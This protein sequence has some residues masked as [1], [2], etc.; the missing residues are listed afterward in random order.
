M[1]KWGLLAA[2]LA[3]AIGVP[4]LYRQMDNR[5][6]CRVEE[7]FAA[8]F[9]DLVVGVHSAAVVEDE[10]IV[11]RGLSLSER[12][13]HGPN[14]AILQL[15]EVLLT[16]PTDLKH[17]VSGRPVVTRVVVR[18][19]TLHVTRCPDGTWSVEKLLP[20]PKFGDRSPEI[21]VENG[22]IVIS[23]PQRVP[24]S[25]L[26]LRDVNLTLGPQESAPGTAGG[27]PAVSGEAEGAKPQAVTQI[28]D[29]RAIKVSLSGDHLR[30]L[31]FE[32]GVNPRAF[33]LAV[34]GTVEELEVS[35]ELRDA[36]P[37]E[38][39]ERLSALGA[40]RGQVS[41]S[42]DV[43]HHPAAGEPT[44]FEISG[45]LSRG[46]VNDPRLPTPLTDMRGGFRANNDGFSVDPFFARSG[47]ASLRLSCRRHGFGENAPM[48]IEAEVR[49]LDVNRALLEVSGVADELCQLWDKYRP[50]GQV[51]ADVKLDYDGHT[52]NPEAT[53]QCLDVSFTHYKFPYRLDRGRGL[54]EIK[55]DVLKLSLEAFS[56][57]RPVRLAAEVLHPSHQPTGWFEAKGD[58]LPLDQKMFD[59][60]SSESRRVVQSL[61]PQGT[62]NVFFRSWVDEPGRPPH[63]HLLIDVNRGSI[64]YDGFPYPVGNIR[65]TIE[66]LDGRWTFRDLVGTNDS[67]RITC[68][69]HLLPIPGKAAGPEPAGPDDPA[70][71][72]E[73]LLQFTATDVPLEEELR[74]AL[75]P[76]LRRLWNDLRPRGRFDLKDVEVRHVTGEPA[77]SVRFRAEPR[78][79]TASIEPV[80]FSYRL[81]KLRGA[82]IFSDGR[83]RLEGLRGEH[84]HVRFAAGGGCEFRPDGSWLLA[85]EDVSVDRLRL[86]RELVKAL[87]DR[88]K[89]ALANLGPDGPMELRGWWELSRGGRPED[90]LCSRWDLKV[91]VAGG[92]VS[93]GIKLE[94]IQGGLTLAGVFDGRNL[95][96][97]GELALDSVTYRDLQFTQVAGPLW[98]DDQQALFGAYADRQRIEYENRLAGVDD[99]LAPKRPLRPVSGRIFGGTVYGSG[100]VTLGEE[101]EYGLQAT[102]ADA[103]L[104]RIAQE[105]IAGQQNLQGRVLASLNLRGAGRSVNTLAGQGAVQVRGADVYELPVM[106][107]LL[108]ILNLRRPDTNAF[109]STDIAYR[110]AGSHIYLDRIVFNGDAISLEGN[111]EIDF[112]GDIRL[113]FHPILGREDRKSF[114]LKELLGGAGQEFMLI[115][116]T[117]TLQ[118]PK[119]T[120]EVFPTVNQALQQL[121]GA[122]LQEFSP[123]GG[124]RLPVPVR[125][126]PRKGLD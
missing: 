48:Q 19:P 102:L 32:G 81:E 99:R 9:K 40:L 124:Q 51:H 8:Q 92:S 78:D 54:L 55:D 17:L 5:V 67:A 34:K 94:N 43:A 23:D 123:Q 63:K 115:R 4:Y 120:K 105:Q 14:A 28:P 62:I 20:L 31:E 22:T 76:S 25:T 84:G 24:P 112:Q 110:I 80:H 90:L 91:N 60:L 73:L 66:G 96:T 13:T 35:P 3:V 100:W 56:G 16:C 47:Q 1:L 104:A 75:H 79:D 72:K 108:K 11:I 113:N 93:S 12:G 53:V 126:L 118:D 97:W 57:N 122:P 52:W 107:A 95:A 37:K 46:R 103:D 27:E 44:R 10:G 39:A 88:L 111:G 69:G 50:Y 82:M 109:G 6:R 86:D 89:K 106:I 119:T 101:T 85:L 70:Q 117:G 125:R 59:A 87:P 74:D 71:P 29:L 77:S 45:R 83:V 18:R 64:C 65:G 121:T 98:I 42:F 33:E 61:K 36:L 21:I 38:L 49:H 41:L 68:Q 114:V 2:V 58:D 26:T 15:D 7:M 116:V 30:R